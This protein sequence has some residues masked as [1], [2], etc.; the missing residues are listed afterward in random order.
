MAR[1]LIILLFFSQLLNMCKKEPNLKNGESL[2]NNYCKS[3]HSAQNNNLF[4][5]K[6]NTNKSVTEIS[7]TINNGISNTE[8]IG[9]KNRLTEDEVFN[10]AS[11]IIK[12][13]NDSLDFGAANN[14]NRKEK[15]QTEQ[16]II[17]K[18][19]VNLLRT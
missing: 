16:E 14:E 5:K 6:W 10:L 9:F 17:K 11:Y 12:K 1:A 7:K 13:L 18:I 15:Y 19:K 2:Y 3:C 4:L 8:M